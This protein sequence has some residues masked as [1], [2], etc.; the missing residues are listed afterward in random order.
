MS[1]IS[2]AF[3][4]DVKTYVDSSSFSLDLFVNTLKNLKYKNFI[5]IVIL[6]FPLNDVTCR[7]LLEDF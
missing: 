6:L 3:A 4:L 7:V 1:K 2:E 5:I